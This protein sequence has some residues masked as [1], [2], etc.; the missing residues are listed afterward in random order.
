MGLYQIK[1]LSHNK[2]TINK[3]AYWE[4]ILA[5]NTSNKELISKPH[6]ELIQLNIQKQ[7]KKIFKWARRSEKT[8]FQRKQTDG[9]KTHEKM[10]N[11]TNHQGNA[12]Q[13]HNEIITSH[14]LEQLSSKTTQITTVGEDVKKRKPH[15]LL[16]GM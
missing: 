9:Q 6:K 5:N 16:V 14:L 2:E 7:T 12:N 11:I 3:R 4:E 1:T 8:L 13:N 15:T 10:F